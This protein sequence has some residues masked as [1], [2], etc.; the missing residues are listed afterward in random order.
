MRVR[1]LYG[2]AVVALGAFFPQLADAGGLYTT[3]RGVRPLARG[4]AFVA[5]ADDLGAIVYNPAGIYDAGSALFLDASWVGFSADYTR[6]TLLRQI[7][8][9]TGEVVATYEQTFPTVESSQPFLAIPTLAGSFSPHPDWMLAFGAWVPYAVTPSYGDE[10]SG[11]PA[12]Q[13]YSLISL[14]GTAL[15][16]IGGWAAWAPIDSLRLGLGVELM[17]GAF[18]T[19]VAMSG[20]L[21]ER[22]FCAP[23]DP[24]WD[25]LSQVDAGP[26]FSPSFNL[27]AIWR[28]AE[29]FRLG[30]SYQFPFFVRAPATVQT[31]LPTTAVFDKSE[32]V[33]ESATI[34]FTLPMQ[35][36]LGVEMRDL[37]EGLRVEL[38]GQYDHWTMHDS[39][40]LEPSDIALTNL[41]GFPKE[42]YV[43]DIEL[44][45]NFQGTGS[46]KLGAEYDIPASETVTVTPRAGVS[47]E[48]SAIPS[49]YLSVLT[50]DST[51][52][53][54]SV[55][56]AVT[57]DAFRI[58]AVYAHV[59]AESVEVAAEDAKI[60]QVVPLVANPAKYPD[61]V[62]GGIYN[63]SV[64][65]VGLGASYTFGHP[66][67][68]TATLPEEDP[69]PPAPKPKEPNQEG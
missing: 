45:R 5:G 44:P 29:N 66:K 15:A 10:V 37:P 19:Q 64:N 11:Q 47:F 4:G 25:V 58:E 16:V 49:D 33:G 2:A 62:N 24:E 14:E 3:D 43:P 56:L 40:S 23:E 8:P 59:F 65:V 34:A 54:P 22:F 20:C 32:Q 30:A 69:E 61:T 41:P 50:I 68:K 17:M 28:F 57:I 67:P 60:E 38:A 26:I 35:F 63:W 39:I 9:N 55:G 46:V 21:P 52:V 27:G 51:K 31:R 13:R 18:S 7:D 48:T 6:Q 12:P 36:R 1:H 53:T 42:Y